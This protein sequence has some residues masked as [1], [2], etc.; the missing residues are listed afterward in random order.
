MTYG[1]EAGRRTVPIQEVDMAGHLLGT[2]WLFQWLASGEPTVGGSRGSCSA[3]TA[4]PRLDLVRKFGFE[5]LDVT[6]LLGPQPDHLSTEHSPFIPDPPPG[7]QLRVRSG[8]R[9][10]LAHRLRPAG[11]ARRKPSGHRRQPEH[12]A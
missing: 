1:T 10:D 12:K 2:T 9:L 8:G 11:G 4:Y 5:D 7:W 3:V 6:I